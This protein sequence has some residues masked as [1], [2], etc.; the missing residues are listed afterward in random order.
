[1]EDT[2]DKYYR[3]VREAT[4]E[5]L[6]GAMTASEV[7]GTLEMVKFQVMTIIKEMQDA[8]DLAELGVTK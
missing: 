4:D 5:V 1:M 6:R 7:L 3:I 8:A 2:K